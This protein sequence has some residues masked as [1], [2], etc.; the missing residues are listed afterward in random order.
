MIAVFHVDF[1]GRGELA[2][3]QQKLAQMLF[4]LTTLAGEFH[5]TVYITN[6]II[7]DLCGGMFI[8][9]PKKPAGGHVLAHA[10]TIRLMPSQGKANNMS[11]RPSLPLIFPKEM[12]YLIS[13]WMMM[14][15][16]LSEISTYFQLPKP[17]LVLPAGY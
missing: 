14:D 3:R 10:T 2:E 13:S 4:Q 15:S 6:P 16:S 8:T 5:V 9:D 1:S 7:V 17:G 11:T 12:R